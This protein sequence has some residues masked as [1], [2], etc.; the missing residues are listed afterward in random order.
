MPAAI[1]M[2]K[3]CGCPLSSDTSR[4]S[5]LGHLAMAK[6]MHTRNRQQSLQVRRA[7]GENSRGIVLEG[8]KAPFNV[9]MK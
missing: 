3:N 1:T 7:L 8:K 9:Y 5:R 6:A 4:V 2:R